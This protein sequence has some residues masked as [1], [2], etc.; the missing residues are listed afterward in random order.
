MYVLA[1]TIWSTQLAAIAMEFLT[2]LS[3]WGITVSLF[4]TGAISTVLCVLSNNFPTVLNLAISLPN[5]DS[6]MGEAM[7]YA[8]LIGSAD[9]SQTHTH[10]QPI[11][12]TVDVRSR[13]LP[14]VC[15]L[16]AILSDRRHFNSSSSPS[17][18]SNFNSLDTNL[19]YIPNPIWTLLPKCLLRVISQPHGGVENVLPN[20]LL[21]TS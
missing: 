3:G 14:I 5:L 2:V 20:N 8:S 17:D 9:R 15:Q 10:W 16:A 13:T 7:V 19:T 1:T 21:K 4:G 11:N 12:L 18:F 6:P